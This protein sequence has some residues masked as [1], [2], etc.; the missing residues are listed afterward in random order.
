M[1]ITWLG[2]ACFKVEAD[3]YTVVF[4][5]YKDGSVP[6]LGNVSET[7][8][9]VLCSHEHGD[10][11]G[12]ECVKITDGTAPFTVTKIETYHDETKGT[13]RGPN[14]IH[15]LDDGTCKV[16]H[17]GDL[18]CDLEPAQIELLKDMDAVMIP[19][20]GFFTIDAKQAAALIGEIQP[21]MAIPMHFRSDKN[22]KKNFGYDVIGT[23]SEFTRLFEDVKVLDES[24]ADT[25][26]AA[27]KIVVLQP[28]N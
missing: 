21:K 14:T 19:V 7:A 4:D 5:P 28:A 16:A 23:V 18:G 11:S 2:H 3:G 8:N 25:A 26:E 27:A 24:S 10:H 9:M 13:K 6:G 17:L 15:I 12:R 1:K 20:G 22:M